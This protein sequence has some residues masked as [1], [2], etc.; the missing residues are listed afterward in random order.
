[1]EVADLHR[2]SLHEATRRRS[3]SFKS[4]Y[5]VVSHQIFSF[6][7][8]GNLS[9]FGVANFSFKPLRLRG[10]GDPNNDSKF[11]EIPYLTKIRFEWDGLPCIDFQERILNQLDNGLGSMLHSG[12]TLL[13]T[14]NRTDPGGVF[15]NP[16][17]AVA[18]QDKIDDSD[19][20]NTKAFSCILNYIN[21]RSEVY[22]MYMRDMNGNGIQVYRHIAVFGPLP[23]PSKVIQAREDS[24]TR[25][26]M[27]SLRI[28]YSIKGFFQWTEIVMAQGRLLGKNG[29]QQKTKL[30]AGYPSFFS[31]T[32]NA[33]SRDNGHT[34][35]AR[36]GLVAGMSGHPLA[37]QAHPEAGRSDCMSLTRAYLADW[38]NGTSKIAKHVPD[39]MVRSADVF[40]LD[41]TEVVELLAKDITPDTKCFL[42]G[43]DS[44]TA[45][46]EL[47]NGEKI[48]C[49]KKLLQ[50]HNS[51]D[52]H[53]TRSSNNSQYKKQVK[54]LQLELNEL[55]IQLEDAMKL[56]TTSFRDMRRRPF[57]K[58]VEQAMDDS[59]PSDSA[60]E[61]SNE[62]ASDDG[63]ED[64]HASVVQSFA[65]VVQPRERRRPKS[66]MSRSR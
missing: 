60:A 58:E 5:E 56:K 48:I 64:S 22:K 43:G 39:G 3:H 13:M 26:T 24:W 20:R 30:L 44:H 51:G 4:A 41:P 23:T 63:S 10:S 37:A 46:C 57:A 38:V 33:M 21:P 19:L 27:D 18:P 66:P 54:E 25:M 1:M 6:G 11:N 31:S 8:N 42:C 17:R 35:P 29:D 12:A 40:A 55:R 7:L 32:M 62:V 47:P 15:G 14:V 52:S 59:Q 45:S 16:M 49:A 53:T 50:Q 28:P 34:F 61:Q 36:Y 9:A 2:P 65:E